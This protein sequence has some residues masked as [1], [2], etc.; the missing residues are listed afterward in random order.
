MGKNANYNLEKNATK[1]N[2]LFTLT[3][4]T[5]WMAQT[6]KR[7]DFELVNLSSK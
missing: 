3:V 6:A 7:S 1:D 4:E 2:N 5:I